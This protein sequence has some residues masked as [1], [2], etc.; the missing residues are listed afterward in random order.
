[1]R[2]AVPAGWAQPAIDGCCLEHD[3]QNITHIQRP[4]AHPGYERSFRS[5]EAVSGHLLQHQVSIGKNKGGNREGN[6]EADRRVPAGPL[7]DFRTE[8]IAPTLN[9]NCSPVDEGRRNLWNAIRST[10]PS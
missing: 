4:P 8:A 7:R 9:S 6:D 10:H 1:M 3:V 5:D 2:K